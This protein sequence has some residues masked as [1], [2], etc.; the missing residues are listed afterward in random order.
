MNKDEVEKL[1]WIYLRMIN[2]HDENQN[3]DYMIALKKIIEKYKVKNV[4]I[5]RK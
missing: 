3:M 5:S 4:T 1:E 2:L